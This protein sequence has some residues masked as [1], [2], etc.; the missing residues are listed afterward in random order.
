MIILNINKENK[1]LIKDRKLRC[2][3]CKEIQNINQFEISN[4][5]SMLRRKQCKKCRKELNRQAYLKKK[6]MLNIECQENQ[7]QIDQDL[8]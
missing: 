1:I 5:T 6:S 3:K 4:K 7:N 2:R 8:S